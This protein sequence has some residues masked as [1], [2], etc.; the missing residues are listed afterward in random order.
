MNII[1]FSLG[2][3]TPNKIHQ[4]RSQT[5]PLDNEHT[6][7][8]CFLDVSGDFQKKIV[9]EFFLDFCFFISIFLENDCNPRSASQG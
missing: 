8:T 6:Q 4:P 1:F 9:S 2:P 7:K 5:T 3:R